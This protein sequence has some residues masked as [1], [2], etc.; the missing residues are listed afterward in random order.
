MNA[1]NVY[2]LLSY[3]LKWRKSLIIW[4]DAPVVHAVRYFASE[5]VPLVGFAMVPSPVEEDA[6]GSRILILDPS[7]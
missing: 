4:D 6:N 7:V 2:L 5:F 3:R 1:D